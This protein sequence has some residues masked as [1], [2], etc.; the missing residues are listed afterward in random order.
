MSLSRVPSPRAP[1]DAIGAK[2]TLFLMKRLALSA[3]FF[4]AICTRSVVAADMPASVWTHDNLAAWCIVPFDSKNRGPEERAQM[5]DRLGLK[6]LAYDW[7]TQHVPTF[8]AEVT[9]MKSHGIDI[10]A[11]WFPKLDNDSRQ[12]LAVIEKHGIHPQLWVSGGGSPA[13]T[14]ADQHHRIE[15]ETARVRPIAVEARRLGCKVGLYNHGGWFGD[16]ENELEILAQL[17]REGFTNIGLV[18]NF[19]HGHNDI[20]RFPAL[21][22]RIMGHVLAVSL[23][24][25][26]THGDRIGK[27]DLIISDG[28]HELAMMRV[29]EQSGWHGGVN[30]ICDRQRV[31]AEDIL[32]QNIA[33][34]DKLVPLLR[35][36]APTRK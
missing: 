17:N 34:L 2:N 23:N 5:L 19:H 29:I 14:D 30:I 20:D 10:V 31:D 26:V 3:A 36:P 27:N 18:Y 35:A 32:A 21:W 6:H 15:S 33:G 1:V 22:P 24:G 11:W 12:A 9:T 4:A 25:M 28:D 13:T 7:R 16:P 8:D